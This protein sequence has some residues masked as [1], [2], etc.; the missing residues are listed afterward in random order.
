MS[1]EVLP[2]RLRERVFTV[3]CTADADIPSA[4]GTDQRPDGGMNTGV[5]CPGPAERHAGTQRA[6][7]AEQDP[8]CK[9]PR[10]RIGADAPPL[11]VAP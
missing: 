5:S 9:R 4:Q 3:R 2:V 11:Q 1:G 7:R 6:Q 10:R 8:R